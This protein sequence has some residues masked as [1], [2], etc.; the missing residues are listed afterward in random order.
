MSPLICKYC[1]IVLFQ[2]NTYLLQHT[3]YLILFQKFSF[4]FWSERIAII[5]AGL[6]PQCTVTAVSK[7]IITRSMHKCNVLILLEI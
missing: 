7:I 4:A 5:V 2:E 6:V 3:K 1:S